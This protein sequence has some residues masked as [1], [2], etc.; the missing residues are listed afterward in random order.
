[1][2][3]DILRFRPDASTLLLPSSSS[4][5]RS[6]RPA[7]F[8]PAV[9]TQLGMIGAELGNNMESHGGPMAAFYGDPSKRW[10]FLVVVLKHEG[11]LK[12]DANVSAAD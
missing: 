8:R 9:R 4:L 1:M 5:V 7:T 12:G 3:V 11:R 2:R 10:G 6:I